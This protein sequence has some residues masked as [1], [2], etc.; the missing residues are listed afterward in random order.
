MQQLQLDVAFLRPQLRRCLLRGGGGKGDGTAVVE[1]LLEDVVLSGE[2][3]GGVLIP[4][5]TTSKPNRGASTGLLPPFQESNYGSHTPLAHAS[6][7]M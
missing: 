3:G 4:A 2:G 1:Q 6:L 5:Q 7:V